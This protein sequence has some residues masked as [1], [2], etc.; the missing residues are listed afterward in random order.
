MSKYISLILFISV[1]SGQLFAQSFWTTVDESRI[2]NSLERDV[3]PNSYNTLSLRMDDMNKFLEKAPIEK[4]GT[5][6]E[7]EIWL[8]MPLPDGGFERF[9]MFR[10]T[11]MMSGLASKYPGIQTFSGYSDNGSN[12]LLD[13]SMRGFRASIWTEK[14]YVYIDPYSKNDNKYYIS[15]YTKDYIEYEVMSAS[16]GI[17]FED[18]ESV[19]RTDNTSFRTENVPLHTYRLALSC[20]GEH[21]KRF[22]TVED[23]LSDMNT[24]VNRINLVFLNELSIKVVLVDDNDKVIFMD[25][26]TD[27]Y[28]DGSTGKNILPLNTGVLNNNIGL[29]NYDLGHVLT[30]RCTDVGGVAYLGSVCN[31]NKG[32]GVTC[33]SNANFTSYTMVTITCHEMGHQ[34]GASH[35]FNNCDGNESTGSA[36]EPGG[37]STIMAYDGLCGSNSFVSEGDTYYHNYSLYQ[38]FRNTRNASGASCG[39]Y[40]DIG[41]HEPVALFDY[42]DGF[43]IPIS[44]PF[45]LTGTGTDEDGDTLTY[46]WEEMDKGPI[47]PLGEPFGN[48]PLFRSILPDTNGTR[49]FP[50]IKAIRFNRTIEEELLPSYSRDLKFR[51][52]VRD[53][54]P[55][56]GLVTWKQVDFKSTK[57]AGPFKVTYPNASGSTYVIGEDMEVTWDVANTDG[58]RVNTQY[59]N[60]YISN[61]DGKTFPRLIAQKTPNDGSHNIRV[62][63]VLTSKARII[64]KAF[65]NVFFDM[66]NNSF[67]IINPETGYYFEPSDRYRELCLPAQTEFDINTVSFGDFNENIVF[68]IPDALP[69]GITASFS[70]VEVA[71]GNSTILN[72]DLVSSGVNGDISFIIR[73]IA[74]NDTLLQEVSLSLTSNDFSELTLISPEDNLIGAAQMQVFNWNDISDAEYYTFEIATNPAFGE[75]VFHSAENIV[76]GSYEMNELL[77]TNSVYYWHVIGYNKC[78]SEVSS[79]FVFGTNA[80]SCE[81]Y[82]AT[83]LPKSISSTGQVVIDSKFFI[84]STSKVVDVNVIKV[85]ALHDFI[86]DLKGS[87]ISPAGTEVRLWSKKCLNL[88]KINCGFDDESTVAINCPMTG[89]YPAIDNLSAFN[90][91]DINGQW[92]LRVEDTK[93]GDGGDFKNAVIEI[94]ANKALNSP[95]L[96]NNNILGVKPSDGNIIKNNFLLAKD[97]DNSADEL[98]FTITELP[99]HGT[100]LFNNSTASLGAQFSQNDIDNHKLSY[101]HSGDD[102][103]VDKFEFVVVDGQGGWIPGTDFVINIGDQYPSASTDL[104]LEKVFNVYPIPSSNVIHIT[105]N[106]NTYEEFDIQLFDVHGQLLKTINRISDNTFTI[107]LDNFNTGIYVL[108]ISIGTDKLYKKISIIK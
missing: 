82:E 8:D 23:V 79:T 54:H 45:V 11:A 75:T 24:G 25:S 61:D 50:N 48:S 40:T 77:E 72:L 46:I 36:F 16:C 29:S 74:G 65:D 80:S 78:K 31:T 26:S 51:F 32:G 60:I 105:K 55:G 107:A 44:T 71:P 89:V 96:F 39:S 98:I 18:I 37:G 106:I 49:Y 69:D 2:Q 19:D 9:N 21:G 90:G 14:G 102:S 67:S 63:N 47:V 83:N 81:T 92:I 70:N 3:V 1:F 52:V 103:E 84:S 57:D 88:S 22:S 68:D 100:L 85:Y 42:E 87:L 43:Y 97:D 5:N 104:E 17:E 73:G 99:S 58:P 62:P 4:Y 41:N 86:K 34:F 30:K 13:F 33:V 93:S 15:Y 27:P 12:M 95:Y 59:V 91:E 56:G 64:V 20:T 35:T 38:I 66:S 101:L 108:E 6:Q 7:S 53:N 28:P 10:S 76:G 94:C